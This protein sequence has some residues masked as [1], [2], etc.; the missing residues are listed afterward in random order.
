METSKHQFEV[1]MQ[2]RGLTKLNNYIKILAELRDEIEKGK[3]KFRDASILIY[4][5]EEFSGVTGN[6]A[7][8]TTAE[9]CMLNLNIIWRKEGG[10]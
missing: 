9:Y 1:G 8:Y 3:V 7:T 6:H 10:E 4:A 5:P 2:D